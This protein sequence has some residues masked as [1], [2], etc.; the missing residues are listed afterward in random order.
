[1]ADDL[2]L[3]AALKALDEI[4]LICSGALSHGADGAGVVEILEAISAKARMELA[5]APAQTED[6]L[7]LARSFQIGKLSVEWRDD[8][9]WAVTDCGSVLS[10]DGEWVFEPLPSRRT[11]EFKA[12]TRFDRETAIEMARKL[13]DC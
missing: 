1:M 8:D 5:K 7:S 9:L 4:A 13:Q 3:T 2:K 10:S 12:R 6:L 11:D